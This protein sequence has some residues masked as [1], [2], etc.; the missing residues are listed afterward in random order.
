MRREP[1]LLAVASSGLLACSGHEE[2]IRLLAAFMPGDEAA[3]ASWLARR[4]PD[5]PCRVLVDLPDEAYEI[6]DLPRVRGGDRRALFARRLAH[7]FPEPRFAR[8]WSLGAPSE[9]RKGFER[10]LFSGLERSAELMPWLERLEADGRRPEL[11]APAA[12]LLPRLPLPGARQ[13]RHSKGPSRP[14]LVAASGRA[15]LRI[16]LL[17]R[18]HTLFSRLL[19]A[20]AETLSDPQALA[21]EFERTRDYLVAQH[22]IASD[23][24]LDRIAVDLPAHPGAEQAT[25]APVGIV[26]ADTLAVGTP[27]SGYDAHLL[28]ALR[29]APATIGWPLATH[30]RRWPGL[31]GRRVFAALGIAVAML[32][33]GFVWMDRLAQA[34]AEA[35]AA[36]ERARA[37]RTAALAAE[38]AERTAREAE[39]AALAALDV[40]PPAPLP[41]TVAAPEPEPPAI[42][43]P[44]PATCPPAS[45]PPPLPIPRRIDGIL[46]RPDGEVLLWVEGS[47]QSARSLG[48]RPTAGDAAAVSPAGRRTRLRSGDSLPV[49]L[50]TRAI[51]AVQ[52]HP[53]QDQP[54]P[55]AREGSSSTHPAEHGS[56]AAGSALAAPESSLLTAKP[57][58]AASGAQP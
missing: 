8:A 43:V 41:P 34:E 6:E 26:A 19:R 55:T 31:A 25:L 36:A 3:F 56:G 15:G 44:T 58:L 7:W 40:A 11:L 37:A 10:V 27:P 35:L 12:A 4:A 29:R 57:A 14:R 48:L 49:E 18:E 2:G 30:A 50:S 28:L 42:P 16:A 47:W 17:D 21:S 46:R 5:E 23:T 51:G 9:G 32:L 45:S 24:P 38:E 52:P 20:H 54:A 53:E 22:R 1:L 13:R 33:G 39:R